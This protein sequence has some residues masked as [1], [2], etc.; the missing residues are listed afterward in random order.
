[1]RDGAPGTCDNLCHPLR[2]RWSRRSLRCLSRHATVNAADPLATATAD[3]AP[4]ALAPTPEGAA[5]ASGA[6]APALVSAPPASLLLEGGPHA[7]MLIHGL[8]STPLEMRF[9]AKVLHKAGFTVLCPA[10]PGYSV[11]GPCTDRAQWIAALLREYDAL[12]ARC[13]SVSVGGLCIGAA[14]SLAVARE[15]PGVNALVLLSITLQYDGWALPWYN[16][17]LEPCYRLG[18]GHNFA[19]QERTPFGLKNEALRKRISESMRA[20]RQ[21]AVGSAEIPI[22]FLYQAIRLG[23]EVR[24]A[25]PRIATDTLIM[26]AVDDET[27]SPRNAHT[28]FNEIAAEHKRKLMLGDSYHVICMDNERELVARETV[29]FI[30]ASLARRQ[31]IDAAGRK[32]PSTS[33]ALMRTLRRGAA[34]AA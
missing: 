6:T 17:I 12:A 2:A 21:S 29:R 15:R 32:L 9:V 5:P 14:L 18:I 34:H 22:A 30:F 25:L 23:R 8:N 20:S 27:A 1:M 28:V 19:Y 31:L 3:P 16:F 24:A 26:H 10:V 7:V 13:T 4:S 11:G 33:R